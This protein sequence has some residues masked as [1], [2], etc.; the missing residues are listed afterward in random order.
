MQLCPTLGIDLSVAG[1]RR[2]KNARR[3][4]S[5]RP[6]RSP[7]QARR[8]VLSR[9]SRRLWAGTFSRTLLFERMACEGGI[10]RRAAG[11]ERRSG[12]NVDG[13]SPA[14]ATPTPS[15]PTCQ[16][17]VKPLPGWAEETGEAG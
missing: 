13:Q 17:E 15:A 1:S 12:M 11:H 8:L 3:S 9:Q 14:T 4:R 2:R 16:P 6:R 7:T 10:D 5:H